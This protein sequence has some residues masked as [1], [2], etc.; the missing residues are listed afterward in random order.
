M[1]FSQVDLIIHNGA[2]VSFMKTYHSLKRTNVSPTKYLAQLAMPRRIPLH[3]VSSASVAQLTGLDT[4]GEISFSKWAPGP[5][6]DGYTAAKWVAERHLEKTNEQFGLPVVIHRP[7]SITGEG[8]GR[9][10]L[11]SNMF[12]LRRVAGSSASGSSSVERDTST[13][14]SVHSV[15]GGYCQVYHRRTPQD[16]TVRY[17]YSA[18]ERLFYPLAVVKELTEG[19]IRSAGQDPAGE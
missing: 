11:M 2:D 4:I 3:F 16:T 6:A 13:S 5:D 1:I 17:L 10:D 12:K 9:L 18:G 14:F 15:A 8:S 19:R 7:S